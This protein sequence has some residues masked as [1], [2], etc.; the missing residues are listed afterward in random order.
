MT[1]ENPIVKNAVAANERV[2]KNMTS[3]EL[4]VK[5]CAKECGKAR[6]I[7]SDWRDHARLL[8]ETKGPDHSEKFARAKPEFDKA[9]S[10]L[11]AAMKIVG[12]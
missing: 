8:A 7:L 3:E 5:A 10:A 12:A 1:I 4:M 2:A 6:S 9:Y 11:I